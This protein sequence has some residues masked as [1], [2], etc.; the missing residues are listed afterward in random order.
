MM[1]F[2]I[3]KEGIDGM[4][5]PGCVSR[6]YE[7]WFAITIFQSMVDLPANGIVDESTLNKMKEAVRIKWTIE[8]NIFELNKDV[9]SSEHGFITPIFGGNISS[10]Y[11]KRTYNEI[12]DGKIVQT[13][14]FHDAIDIA[15]PMGTPVYAIAKGEV[16][17]NPDGG[18]GGKTIKLYFGETKIEDDVV[19]KYARYLH[20]ADVPEKFKLATKQMRRVGA[21]QGEFLGYVGNTGHGTG[22]HLHFALH[23]PDDENA[24]IQDPNDE[25]FRSW[26]LYTVNPKSN[27]VN[28]ELTQCQ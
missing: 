11:G 21:E 7:T 23:E 22:F 9:K 13:T 8:K 25:Y 15:V 28:F 2:N 24:R 14:N 27:Y 6:G 16:E 3:G 19:E 4:A 5:G 1:G 18:T 26:Q 20:L 10:K 12:E 17:Y